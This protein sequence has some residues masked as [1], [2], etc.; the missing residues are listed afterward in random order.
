MRCNGV[1]RFGCRREGLARHRQRNSLDEGRIGPL[2]EVGCAARLLDYALSGSSAAAGCAKEGVG[3]LPFV[4]P[5]ISRRDRD[6]D[7][8]DAGSDERRRRYRR[9]RA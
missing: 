9:C 4:S 1:T 3:K 6:L 2:P 7:P 5:G 8:P